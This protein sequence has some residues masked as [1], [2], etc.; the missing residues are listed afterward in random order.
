MPPDSEV[1][2]IVRMHGYIENLIYRNYC[3]LFIRCQG[4]E[5]PRN[6]DTNL[7]VNKSLPAI[8]STAFVT[9]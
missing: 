6:L 8:I 7:M 9:Q 2:V 5:V 3:T 4:V 1:I